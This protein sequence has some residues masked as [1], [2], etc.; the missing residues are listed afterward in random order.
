MI[1][2]PNLRARYT[3]DA[4]FPTPVGPRMITRRRF[5]G[6]NFD[7]EPNGD[8]GQE[9][10][11]SQDLFPRQ[12]G[13]P[14]LSRLLTIPASWALPNV[15]LPARTSAVRI[16]LS[17]R[18]KYFRVS[19]VNRVRLIR[20]KGLNSTRPSARS[21][22]PWNGGANRVR[23]SPSDFSRTL[24]PTGPISLGMYL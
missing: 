22:S 14:I 10:E 12:F 7:Q 11:D 18:M 4:V 1:S 16:S 19:S 9:K 20:G 8:Q 6:C 17:T 5:L 24:K 23:M 21:S 15:F 2:P 13:S 3:P